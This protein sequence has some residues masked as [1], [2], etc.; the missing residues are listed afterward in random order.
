MSHGQLMAFSPAEQNPGGPDTHKSDYNTMPLNHMIHSCAHHCNNT[1]YQIPNTSSQIP[2]ISDRHNMWYIF[3]K[4]IVQ[5]Y[6]KLY[7]HVS[8]A[9]IQKYKYKNTQIKHMTKCQKDPICGIFL[10]RGLFIDIKNY[11]PIQY[12]LKIW[13]SHSCTMYKV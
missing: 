11:I 3:A 5:V 10:E 4:R 8:K 9:Q 1:K 2:N 12:K 13:V 6:Q 7:S